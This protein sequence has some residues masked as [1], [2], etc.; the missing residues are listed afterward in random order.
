MTDNIGLPLWT[1]MWF[2][3]FLVWMTCKL[4]IWFTLPASSRVAARSAAYLLGWP[5]MDPRPFVVA[6]VSNPCGKARPARA[7]RNLIAGNLLLSASTLFVVPHPFVAAWT[8]MIG[9]VLLLHFGLFN[10]IALAWNRAGVSVEPIMHEPTRA[11]SLADFWSRWNRGFRD[12]AFRLIFRPLHRHI[13]IG[14]AMF[15]AFLFSGL[16]HDLVISLPARRGFGL[17]TLYFLVQGIGIAFERSRVGRRVHPVATRILM[18][19][20]LILPLPLLFHRAFIERVFVP[21]ILFLARCK[22]TASI[23]L[24]TLLRIGGVLHFGI[25][26]ASALTPKVLHWRRELGKLNLLTRQLVWVHGVFIVITI[27][28]LGVIATITAPQLALGGILARCVCGFVALFWLA[29]LSLQFILFDPRQ[30][31]TNA[32]LKLGYHGLT[33]V[34]TYLAIVF[35]FAAI[36]PL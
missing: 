26:I 21:F 10:L 35:G 25:L 8:G 16:V 1:E 22:M 6:R 4:I 11:V 30:Y 28:A 19:I 14:A 5:G 13:G 36:N 9:T 33:L 3:A 15:V 23:D 31:L 24:T 17:P 32:T 29:R 2:V 27:I 20:T 34:F 7:A 18:Y 12:L